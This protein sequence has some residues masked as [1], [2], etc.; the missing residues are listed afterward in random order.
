MVK[1]D[2]WK[3]PKYSGEVSEVSLCQQ[4]F[5]KCKRA[6]HRAPLEVSEV[7]LYQQ[8]FLNPYVSQSVL[9]SGEVSEVSLCQQVF[10]KY[11]SALHRAL[12]EISEVSLC[13]Q[14]V[15]KFKSALHKAL[16][17]LRRTRCRELRRQLI[18]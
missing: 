5:F 9:F 18:L 16:L 15:F 8:V 11:K 6:V 13:Q 7:S 10:F 4:V 14:V 1:R 3:F 12:S 17:Y 2:V